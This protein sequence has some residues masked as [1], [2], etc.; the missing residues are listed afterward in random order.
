MGTDGY[1]RTTPKPNVSESWWVKQTTAEANYLEKASSRFHIVANNLTTS[2]YPRFRVAYEM[3]GR[4]SAERSLWV[5]RHSKCF[6]FAK[7]D[8]EQKALYGYTLFLAGA[9]RR[10]RISVGSDSQAGK[11]WDFFDTA[12]ELGKP[13]ARMHARDGVLVRPYT[14]GTVI[15]NTTSSA[16][17]LTVRRSGV[18]LPAHS[19]KIV[20]D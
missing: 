15:V 10:D 18:S 13:A 9:G 8:T 5:L 6:C 20:L 12:A 4:V 14:H 11:W 2:T 7:F 3:F 16:K 17:Q 19:G 1:Q